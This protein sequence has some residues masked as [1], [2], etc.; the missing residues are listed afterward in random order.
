MAGSR[1]QCLSSESGHLSREQPNVKGML[2][3]LF[4]NHCNL[5][6]ECTFEVLLAIA[7]LGIP[8]PDP[9]RFLKMLSRNYTTQTH[10]KS[11]KKMNT[12]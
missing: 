3:Q 4:L 8:W 12:I 11:G 9:V 7:W 2:S 1:G 5:T 6:N 10:T